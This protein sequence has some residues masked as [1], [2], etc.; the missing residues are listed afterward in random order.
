MWLILFFVL[1]K[2]GDAD[3]RVPV[4]G[5]RDCVE[6]LN[7]T[8]KSPWHSWFLNKQVS[9]CYFQLRNPHGILALFVLVLL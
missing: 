6:A 1:S 2:S 4:I 8:L 3:G 9:S 7:L 5:T